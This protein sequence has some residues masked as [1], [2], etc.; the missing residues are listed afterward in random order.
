[1]WGINSIY[2]RFLEPPPLGQVVQVE[3]GVQNQ[4]VGVAAMPYGPPVHHHTL[5]EM[6]GDRAQ[7]YAGNMSSAKNGREGVYVN[8]QSHFVDPSVNH[9]HNKNLVMPVIEERERERWGGTHAPPSP[10]QVHDAPVWQHSMGEHEA[11]DMHEY[12][13]D[14]NGV[15]DSY[16]HEYMHDANDYEYMHDANGVYD[17]YDPYAC[18]INVQEDQSN[19]GGYKYNDTPSNPDLDNPDWNQ[20]P[21]ELRH[22]YDVYNYPD[23]LQGYSNVEVE[24]PALVPREWWGGVGQENLGQPPQIESHDSLIE[25]QALREGEGETPP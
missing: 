2:A 5:H 11:G 19:L 17:P 8:H 15:Y 3:Q 24:K 16:D 25:L 1:M 13:H 18:D 7:S 10:P 4:G 14:A 21:E 12:T 23:Y 22:G 20:D 9:N 6:N